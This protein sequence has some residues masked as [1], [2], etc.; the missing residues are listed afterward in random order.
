[1]QKVDRKI[2]SII[3]NDHKFN[4]NRPGI[5]A[6]CIGRSDCQDDSHFESS[7]IS[8]ESNKSRS[9]QKRSKTH[10]RISGLKSDADDRVKYPHSYLHNALQFEYVS[11]DV[12][13]HGFSFI[14]FVAGELELI[15]S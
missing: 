15:F 5:D 1:M 4:S 9:N 2:D 10:K 11:T 6:Y 12:K 7:V 13:C 14:L 3:I 8:V